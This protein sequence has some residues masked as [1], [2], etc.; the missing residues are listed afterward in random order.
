MMEWNE[1]LE[2]FSGQIIGE[3]LVMMDGQWLNCRVQECN[4]GEYKEIH[5]F[6]HALF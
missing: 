1:P 6:S 3:T 2:K 5:V 4:M